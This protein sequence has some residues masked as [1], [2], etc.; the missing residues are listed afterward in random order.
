MAAIDI[1]TSFKGTSV[2]DGWRSYAGYDC[3]HALCNA[4]HLR[5]LRFLV[6][7]YGQAWADQMMTLLVTMKAAVEQ[8]QAQGQTQKTLLE[9]M[10]WSR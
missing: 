10:V 6:E 5:E 3:A 2:H 4:H 1:L 7:R 9:I 8:A